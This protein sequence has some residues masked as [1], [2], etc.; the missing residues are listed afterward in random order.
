MNK[1]ELKKVSDAKTSREIKKGEVIFKEGDKLK[2]VFCVGSGVSKLSQLSSN[3]KDLIV[4]L[5]TKGEILGQRSVIAEEPA[6]LSAKALSDMKVC[7]IPKD[8]ITN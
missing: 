5:V 1:G 3:G 6:N 8:I 2:G 7:F 4:K